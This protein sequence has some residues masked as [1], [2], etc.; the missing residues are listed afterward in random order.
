MAWRCE[1]QVLV[2]T[3]L[4]VSGQMVDMAHQYYAEFFTKGREELAEQLFD[5]GV[6]H[7]DIVWDAAHPIA[8]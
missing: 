3:C 4:H 2:P 1:A 8:G 7:K 6:V 5:E